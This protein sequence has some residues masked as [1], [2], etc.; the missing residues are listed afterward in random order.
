MLPREVPESQGLS[1]AELP[2]L[3]LR[4]EFQSRGA[5][6]GCIGVGAPVLQQSALLD[7]GPLPAPRLTPVATVQQALQ[8]LVRGRRGAIV[9]VEG[10]RPVGIFTERDVV[11]RIP[12]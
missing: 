12:T 9:V 4:R 1:L 11:Y 10:L 6:A 3:G 2:L 7:L 8:F 5:R